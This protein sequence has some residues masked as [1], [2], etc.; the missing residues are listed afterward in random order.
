MVQSFYVRRLI[1]KEEGDGPNDGGGKDVIDV[2][3]LNSKD[4]RA[5]KRRAAEA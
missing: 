5:A 3:N 4:R 2:E 1:A